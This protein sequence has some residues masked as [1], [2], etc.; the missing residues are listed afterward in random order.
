MAPSAVLRA[1]EAAPRA[2]EKPTPM[3]MA[4]ARMAMPTA[5]HSNMVSQPCAT[6]HSSTLSEATAANPV[7]AWTT[8]SQNGRLIGRRNIHDASTPPMAMPASTVASIAVK[9]SEVAV[10][11]CSINRNHSTSSPSEANPEMATTQ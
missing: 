11:N 4:G 10:T 7:I 8:V 5:R 6:V 3:A 2:S 9:A 1:R